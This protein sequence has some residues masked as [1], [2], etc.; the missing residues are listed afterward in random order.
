MR[1]GFGGQLLL[2][3]RPQRCQGAAQKGQLFILFGVVLAVFGRNA[4]NPE[5]VLVPDMLG[6]CFDFFVL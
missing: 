4:A 1:E 5:D 6:P 3:R 2:P